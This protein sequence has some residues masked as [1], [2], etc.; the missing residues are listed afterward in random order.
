MYAGHRGGQ[1]K[2]PCEASVRSYLRR[3]LEDDPIAIRASASVVP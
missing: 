2:V 3:D 1:Q